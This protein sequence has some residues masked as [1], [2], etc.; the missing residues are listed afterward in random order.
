MSNKHISANSG[1]VYQWRFTSAFIWFIYFSIFHV[2]YFYRNII[3]Q[4][5]KIPKQ[6]KNER[7]FQDLSEE[8]EQT[9]SKIISWKPLILFIPS[10]VKKKNFSKHLVAHGGLRC[11][12]LVF[13][14]RGTEK[15]SALIS[16]MTK[17][18]QFLYIILFCILLSET[19]DLQLHL[20]NK[21]QM[22]KR[23]SWPGLNHFFIISSYF[24]AGK[25]LEMI[26][27]VAFTLGSSGHNA[28]NSSQCK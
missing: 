14:F 22:L 6:D 21:I 26:A 24:Y 15:N 3:N 13:F 23:V 4:V 16:A 8:A 19:Q 28:P 12:L 25:G 5:L 2:I 17:F 9:F 27:S 10:S 1:K 11:R 7:F 18:Q 20:E